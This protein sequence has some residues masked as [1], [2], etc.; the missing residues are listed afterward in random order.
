MTVPGET[1]SAPVQLCRL[2]LYIY[3]ELELEVVHRCTADV[4]ERNLSFR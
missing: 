4:A 1:K 3:C 2:F